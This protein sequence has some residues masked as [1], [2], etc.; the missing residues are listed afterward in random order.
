NGVGA[1]IRQKDAAL[2][3]MFTKAIDET[4]ADGTLEKMAVKWFGFDA[5][6]K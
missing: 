6:T 2:A 4:I 3:E 5:S 1:G